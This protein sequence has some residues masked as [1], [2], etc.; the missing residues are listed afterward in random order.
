MNRLGAFF[1]FTLV[2]AFGLLLVMA[3]PQAVGVNL[4][5][6]RYTLQL[7]F[8][9]LVALGLGLGLAMGFGGWMVLRYRI[10]LARLRRQYDLV[11]Q[12]V[13]NLRRMPIHEA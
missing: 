7:G 3:N 4:Y 1:I 11:Y 8:A 6:A 9:L 13:R 5:F 10:K 2:A 12:E